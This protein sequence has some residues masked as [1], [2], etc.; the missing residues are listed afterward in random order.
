MAD[1]FQKLLQE[2]H[3]NDKG[4][5][6]NLRKKE[7]E[8]KQEEIRVQKLRISLSMGTNYTAA[9]PGMSELDK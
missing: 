9:L 1:I 3:I 7:H 2:T 6:G 8:I 5:V 4:Q